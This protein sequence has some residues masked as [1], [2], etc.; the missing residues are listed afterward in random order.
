MWRKVVKYTIYAFTN[1]AAA[2]VMSSV[3]V[4]H[5]NTAPHKAK[6]EPL[7][8]LKAHQ[9]DDVEMI[10][11][12]GVMVSA[13]LIENNTEKV[14]VLLA[15]KGHNRSESMVK[16]QLYLQQ[17][18]SVLM[19]DLRGTGSSESRRTSFGWNEQKDLIAWYY[20]LRTKGYSKIAAH[21]FSLGAATICYTLDEIN[22]YYFVALESCHP[23]LKK[24]V[25][26]S[27]KKAHWPS[28]TSYLMMP[29]SSRL[30]KYKTKEMQP[31]RYLQ[32]YRG[33]LLILGGDSEKMVPAED[34]ILLASQ[35][36]AKYT[37][38]HLFKGADHQNF[39]EN[40]TEKFKEILGEFIE[41]VAI[42]G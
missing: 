24:V 1:A 30:A 8:E 23:S 42:L 3:Y 34:T 20:Y 21:G 13:W 19:P 38:M 26:N 35:N 18:Y 4:V 28:L 7:P 40:F 33:P 36:N 6:V 11:E 14:V 29:V 17:G 2:A 12:D 25:K 15:G 41:T 9:I 32:H 10:T 5:K 37:K 27:L 31:H 39:S 16:A 22:D